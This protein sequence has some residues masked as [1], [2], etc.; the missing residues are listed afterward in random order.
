[1]PRPLRNVGNRKL[2]G[3]CTKAG[4]PEASNS[5]SFLEFPEVTPMARMLWEAVL[6]AALRPL[7]HWAP[8]D[9]SPRRFG[10]QPRQEALSSRFRSPCENTPYILVPPLREQCS[11]LL[12]RSH[13]C[14]LLHENGF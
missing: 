10:Q 5:R 4:W 3:N 9:L 12:G 1:M 13:R 8:G 14:S 2:G 11:I 7:P 6:V